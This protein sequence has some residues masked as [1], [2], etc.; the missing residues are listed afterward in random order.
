MPDDIRQ[1]PLHHP[2]E[3]VPDPGQAIQVADGIYWIRMPL[4]FALNHINLWLLEDGD[5]WTI[6]DTGLANDDTK[7]LWRAQFDGPMGGKPVNRVIVTHFHP[8]HVGNAGWLA[9]VCKAPVWMSRT[10]WLMH[11][12][13]YMD[14]R[15]AFHLA[16]VDAYEEAGL[17]TE[18]IEPLR[19]A[20]NVYG[21]RVGQAPTSYV[22]LRQDDEIEIGGRIWRVIVGVGHAPEHACLYCPSLNVLI[23]G[24]QILPRI[25]P[26]ISLWAN[27]TGGDPLGDYLDSL[28]QFNTLPADILVL[29]SH[30]LPFTGLHARVEQ[31]AEHHEDR[32]ADIVA[33]CD[34]PKTATDLLPVLFKRELDLHQ[35]GFAMGEA[36]AHLVHLT[37]KDRLKENRGQ[38]GP[39]T[40]E[41]P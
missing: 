6:V 15:A 36:L 29:P 27:D 38:N 5:G 1:S 24:D 18:W 11:Q 31:L 20:G 21:E 19:K 28:A 13:L 40:F 25:T 33:A 4:P 3:A 23:S 7:E 39:V 17:G 9:E 34:T 37:I 35:I 26:N 32:L 2:F 14:D 22:R 30:G 12:M 10:E 8:D 16:Q 41:R